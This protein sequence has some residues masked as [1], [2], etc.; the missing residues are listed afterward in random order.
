MSK[1]YGWI[2]HKIR[3]S[4][5]ASLNYIHRMVEKYEDFWRQP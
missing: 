2:D 3:L 4:W 1:T 5:K